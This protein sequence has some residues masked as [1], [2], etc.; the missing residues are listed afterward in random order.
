MKQLIGALI[1]LLGA[2]L[3]G[4]LVL[5]I[6]GVLVLSEYA[7]LRSGATLLVLAM[8]FV[9]LLVVWFG[10]FKDPRAGYDTRSGRRAQPRTGVKPGGISELE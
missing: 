5:R 3:A 2:G 7:L 1:L 10:F 4:L 8:A 9:G 6:W